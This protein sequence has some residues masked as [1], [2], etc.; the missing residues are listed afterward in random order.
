MERKRDRLKRWWRNLIRVSDQ[1]S[2][3]V[4]DCPPPS[5]EIDPRT[6]ERALRQVEMLKQHGRELKGAT[7]L[8]IG[9]C[10]QPTIPLIFFLAGCD[11][12]VLVDR[13]RI[14]DQ[15]LLT[16]TAFNLRAHAGEIA[17]RL[18]L[19]QREVRQQLRPAEGATFFGVLRHFKMQYLAPCDLLKT[20]L[21]ANSVD[22][23]TCRDLLGR[24]SESYVRDLL[25]AVAKIIKSGGA[26]TYCI[27]QTDRLQYVRLIKS[28]DFDIVIDEFNSVLRVVSSGVELDDDR[29]L[30]N[31]FIVAVPRKLDQDASQS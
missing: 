20:N 4:G 26:M 17:L 14:L 24:Y 1:D 21:P 25:P 10:W 27:D 30:L 9:T 3:L 28:S 31:S 2:D 13:T 23:V 6:L 16:R 12:L 19:D 29:N 22:V 18:G 7:L 11:D 8:N 5:S 15:E